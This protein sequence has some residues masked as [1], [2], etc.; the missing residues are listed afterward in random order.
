MKMDNPRP[1]FAYLATALRDK[2]LRMAY[3]HAVEPRIS[4]YDEVGVHSSEDSEFLREIWKGDEGGKERVSIT[5]GGHDLETALR[6]AERDGELIVLGR[7]YNV[8]NEREW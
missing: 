5:A 4:G 1:T 6:Y 2:H 7:L 8:H 3:L